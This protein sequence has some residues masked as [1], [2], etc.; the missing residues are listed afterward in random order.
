[1]NNLEMSR[2]FVRQ[3]L[4]DLH[5]IAL[6]VRQSRVPFSA[7]SVP[8]SRAYLSR[9]LVQPLKLKTYIERQK[10]KKAPDIR[11]TTTGR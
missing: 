7:S 2:I 1:M 10:K 4:C 11:N 9:R 5:C 8:H 6:T 3:L